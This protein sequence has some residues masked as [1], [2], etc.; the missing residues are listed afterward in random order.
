MRYR[1][2]VRLTAADVGSRVVVRWR[3]QASAGTEE[4]GGSAEVVTDVLGI[5]EAADGTALHVRKDSGE[6]VAIPLDRALAGKAVPPK[7]VRS[8]PRQAPPER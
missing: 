4:S 3:R 2:E 1:M 8:S 7:P 5:L 6:L